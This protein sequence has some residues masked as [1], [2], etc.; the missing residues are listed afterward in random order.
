MKKGFVFLMLVLG[1]LLLNPFYVSANTDFTK[2]VNEKLKEVN[3]YDKGSVNVVDSVSKETEIVKVLSTD[4]PNTEENEEEIETYTANVFAGAVEYKLKRD[5]IFHMKKHD[6]FIFD[7]DNQE[8]I[9]LS[10]VPEDK[11]IQELY[12]SFM[13]DAG[14]G[15]M[16]LSSI[17]LATFLLLLAVIVVPI[18]IMIFHN[19]SIPAPMVRNNSVY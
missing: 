15:G 6:F 16:T 8:F 17:F 13:E 9:L 18:L 4:D 14:G 10:N 1:L 5:S 19:K 7:V 11:E 3:Y 12:N 2:S